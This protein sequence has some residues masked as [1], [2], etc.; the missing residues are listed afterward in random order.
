M[1]NPLNC[2]EETI[3]ETKPKEPFHFMTKEELL[4]R[5][6]Q[7]RQASLDAYHVQCREGRERLRRGKRDKRAES[8]EWQRINSGILELDG[9]WE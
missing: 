4:Q 9:C 8:L 2:P 3:S 5:E 7:I 1:K 6:E